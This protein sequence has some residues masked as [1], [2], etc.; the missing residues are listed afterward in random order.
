MNILLRV[1][2]CLAIA[3]SNG[4]NAQE[5]IE[6][7]SSYYSV[8]EKLICF[9][10]NGFKVFHGGPIDTTN[11]GIKWIMPVSFED[12]DN[13]TRAIY[14]VAFINCTPNTAEDAELLFIDVSEITIKFKNN[15]TADYALFSSLIKGKYKDGKYIVI[16]FAEI[17]NV[18]FPDIFV[19]CLQG[20]R[21]DSDKDTIA[22]YLHETFHTRKNFLNY[23]SSPT[24][25][26]IAHES[27][28]QIIYQPQL[29]ETSFDQQ[30]FFFCVVKIVKKQDLWKVYYVVYPANTTLESLATCNEHVLIRLD[31]GCVSGQIYNDE[32][33]DCIDQ[34]HEGLYQLTQEILLPGIIIHIPTHDGRGFGTAP[35]AETEI[36]KRGGNGRIHSTVS[37]DTIAAAKLLYGVDNYDIRSFDGAAELL[38]S[39]HI[40]KVI[41]LT[42]NVNKISLLQK[43]GIEVLRKKTKTN[44][45][46]C[47][48]HI[49]AKKNSKNY[50]TD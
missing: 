23:Y 25:E 11:H 10:R 49:E 26:T 40:N 28:D 36:Y 17:A 46:S 12:T 31:S 48:L 33:C 30:S 15:A 5:Q 13:K 32:A 22:Y 8:I 14:E 38:A 37:L 24:I 6:L 2:L 47:L 35:K 18:Y 21:L 42:D 27:E 9:N 7:S 16:R 19:C 34:L 45:P 50:F 29:V 3:L 4:V 1:L 20:N 39:L 44:K 43:Y 41:L